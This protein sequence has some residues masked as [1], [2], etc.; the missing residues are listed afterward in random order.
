MKFQFSMW[1]ILV[2]TVCK[3]V[4]VHTKLE[5][6]YLSHNAAAALLKFSLVHFVSCANYTEKSMQVYPDELVSMT[7]CFI[8]THSIQQL[9]IGECS[10]LRLPTRLAAL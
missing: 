10:Q 1:I 7:I 5:T 6:L 2:A 9:V 3:R 8:P 4:F